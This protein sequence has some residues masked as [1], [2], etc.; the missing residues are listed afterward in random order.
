MNKLVA[1]LIGLLLVVGQANII[2]IEQLRS[3]GKNSL[4]KE[5]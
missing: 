3:E 4:I 5:I 1:T 2:N